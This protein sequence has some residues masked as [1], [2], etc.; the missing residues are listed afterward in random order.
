MS[1]CIYLYVDTDMQIY[2][3][4][5]KCIHKQFTLEQHGFE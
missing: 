1:V 4:L 2:M 5:Y 3:Y